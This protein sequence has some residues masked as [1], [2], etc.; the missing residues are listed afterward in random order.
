MEPCRGAIAICSRGIRGLILSEKPKLVT[1]P[2]GSSGV[3]WTGV[4]LDGPHAGK[5]WSSRKPT[6]C[7]VIDIDNPPHRMEAL[8]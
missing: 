5:P 8:S 2:D 3:S 4:C 1:Y 6:V 7:S